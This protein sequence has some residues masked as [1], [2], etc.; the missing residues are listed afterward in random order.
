MDKLERMKQEAMQKLRYWQKML[1]LFTILGVTNIW[2]YFRPSDGGENF[3]DYFK[4]FQMGIV[5]ALLLFSVFNF[6][7]FRKILQDEEAL[8]TWYITEHDERN[9]EIWA[10]SG[11]TALYSCGVLIIGAAIVAGYFSPTVFITLLACG[12]FLMVTKKG[13]ILYYRKTI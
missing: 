10:K 3:T 8:R 2:N 1:S 7:K 9:A 12:L 4:G 5:C 13:L 11:G 6:M